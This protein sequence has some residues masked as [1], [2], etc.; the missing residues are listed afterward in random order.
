MY[1]PDNWVILEMEQDGLTFYKV[2]GGWSGGYLGS[3]SWR[4]NSGIVD[5]QENEEGYWDF[6]GSSGAVYRCWKESEFTRMNN[7]GVVNRLVEL[8]AKI[9]SVED[10]DVSDLVKYNKENPR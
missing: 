9:V 5:V 2:C 6:V 4:V 1:K 8:G 7:A 10:I 3:D